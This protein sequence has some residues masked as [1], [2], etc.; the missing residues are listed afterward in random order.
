MEE[1]EFFEEDLTLDEQIA[2][3]GEKKPGKRGRKKLSKDK[4]KEKPTKAKS[5]AKPGGRLIPKTVDLTW[6]VVAVICAFV[7]G[8]VTRGFFVVQKATTTMPG[9]QQ[10]V[11]GGQEAPP[12]TPEQIEQGMPE[13]H[14]PLE[15][16]TTAPRETETETSTSESTAP[17]TKP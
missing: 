17:T 16:E 5:K 6:V 1:E 2:G 7:L 14:P 11:P 12:L 10:T 13:G 3:E 9:T 4:V 15:G 8:F